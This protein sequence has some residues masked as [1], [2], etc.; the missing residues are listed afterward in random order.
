MQKNVPFVIAGHQKQARSKVCLPAKAVLKKFFIILFS[1]V[2]LFAC[3]P[4][5]KIQKID[6]AISKK[7]TAQTVAVNRT[8][9]VDSTRIVSD[10]LQKMYEKKIDFQTFTAKAKVEFETAE[11]TEQANVQIRLQKDS[12]LWASVTGAL[13][14]EGMRMLVTRDSVIV[15]N[16]LKKTVQYRSIEYLQ[17]LTDIP[18]DF[19]ILQDIIVGNP[20]F[21]EGKIVSYKQTDDQW[22]VLLVG[23]IYKHLLTLDND[24]KLIHSKLDDVDVSR[25]RTCD[26]TYGDFVNENGLIF[27]KDRHF[28]VSEKSKLDVRMEFRQFS[29]NQPLTFPFNIPKNFKIK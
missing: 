15:M 5:K 16:K 6:E 22:L 27:S 12:L 20:I 10:I 25:N 18:F 1:A 21:T 24:Y 8:Q 14:I 9:S 23:N 13:G 17:E 28:T 4:A 7:D 3:R 26:I 19:K 29:F 2:A 11:E